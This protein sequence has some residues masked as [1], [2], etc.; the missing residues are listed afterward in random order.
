[1]SI[2]LY[3]EYMCAAIEK[4]LVICG[5]ESYLN[6]IKFR[7]DNHVAKVRKVF[8]EKMCDLDAPIPQP[9]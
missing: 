6:L 9:M 3:M 8:D 2:G 1:M 4:H 7:K 5:H